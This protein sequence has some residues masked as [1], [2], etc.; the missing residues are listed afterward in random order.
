MWSKSSYFT[1]PILKE[2]TW[3]NNQRGR[4]RIIT[5]IA[6]GGNYLQRLSESH[7]ISKQPANA[8]C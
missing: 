3:R 1:A 2:R 7:L 6:Q 4:E 5:S 8:L